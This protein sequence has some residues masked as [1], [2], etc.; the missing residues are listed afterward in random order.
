M[1]TVV[2]IKTFVSRTNFMLSVLEHENLFK[3]SGP[4]LNLM[5]SSSLF[6]VRTVERVRMGVEANCILGTLY[7]M[8]PFIAVSS[9]DRKKDDRQFYS[10]AGMTD[11]LTAAGWPNPGS[12]RRPFFPKPTLLPFDNSTQWIFMPLDADT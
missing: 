2:G 10:F 5:V 1:P 12:K 8:L 11:S 4:D 6:T 7:K 9:T 3:T